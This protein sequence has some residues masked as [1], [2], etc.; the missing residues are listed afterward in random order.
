MGFIGSA[1]LRRIIP[2]YPD[3]LFINVDALY[4][5]SNKESV[6]EIEDHSNYTFERA[7][8]RDFF[9]LER[10]FSRYDISDIIHFAAQ[11]DVDKS[12]DSRIITCDT[13][14]GGTVNLLE[15]AKEKKDFGRFL[16]VSTD[17]VYGAVTDREKPKTE[18]DRTN[19]SN[20]YAASKMAAEGL[21]RA[22]SSTFGLD[23]VITRGANT[24][25]P[26]QDFTKLIPVV[27]Q[28]IIEEREVPLYGDGTQERMWLPLEL[29]AEGIEVVWQKGKSGE[30]YNVSGS[31]YR[32]N[33]EVVE[34]I[35][36]F[37]SDKKLN[38]K[39]VTDR[40][41]HDIRYSID[42]S[43][44]KSLGWPTET[45][46]IDSETFFLENLKKTVEWYKKEL[47]NK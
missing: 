31:T 25:G 35:H 7:D 19:P 21:V 39:F 13:N 6:A 3:T 15:Q 45:S 40:P 47:M 4:A 8:I 36:S 41:G 28:A 37:L 33:K 18:R 14:I 23:T 34:K 44:I 5:G 29:H 20:P 16:Y 30:I 32:K 43:K 26:G 2:K 24:F 42:N 9:E 27:I 12:I 11:T 38:I 1:F 17:E 10:L 22:Y 46:D